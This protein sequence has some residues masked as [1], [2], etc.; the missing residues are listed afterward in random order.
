MNEAKLILEERFGAKYS[1]KSVWYLFKVNKIKLKTARPEN[2]KI[3]KE[4]QEE[5]NPDFESF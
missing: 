5:F 4:K 2:Y 1:I 3:D